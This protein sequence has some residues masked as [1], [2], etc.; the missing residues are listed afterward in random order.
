MRKFILSAFGDEMA[1]NL[2]AQLDILEKFNVKYIEVREVNGKNIVEHSLEEVREVKKILDSRNFKVSSIGSPVGKVNITDEFKPHLKLFRH[3]LDI[4]EILESNYIRMFSFFIPK[5]ENPEKYREEVLDR[6]YQ[7][8]KLAEGRKIILL[9][10]NEK[11]I[12]GDIPERCLDILKAMDSYYVK[13]VFD[14][15]N[16]VQCDVE[17]YPHAF[18]LLK[19]YIEYLHIKDALYK[20]HSVVPVGYGD[21]R[22][23]K[24]LEELYKEGFEGFLSIEPHLENISGEEKFR[25]AYESLEKIIKEV[26]VN[27]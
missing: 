21:G 12:Y 24:I 18:N 2:K 25:V 11:E 7:F 16:F 4:A 27:V 23:K 20:D 8:V 9:H 22:V 1:D 19:D 13:A 6:W 15:A 5:K 14:P 10:E 26:Y 17:T 3:T